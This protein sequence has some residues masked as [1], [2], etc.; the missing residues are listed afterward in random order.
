M[1]YASIWECGIQTGH[2]LLDEL[3][4]SLVGLVICTVLDDV[5]LVFEHCAV[6]SSWQVLLHGSEMGP[7]VV[8]SDLSARMDVS[9][10]ILYGGTTV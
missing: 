7:S 5:S 4:C 8:S 6:W 1:Q 10:A 9:K 3:P 2:H